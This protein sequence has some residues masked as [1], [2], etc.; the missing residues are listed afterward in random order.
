[1]SPQ[2]ARA[3]YVQSLAAYLGERYGIEPAAILDRESRKYSF[4]L[5]RHLIAYRL[6]K[7]HWTNKEI[8]ELL[9]L[10]HSTISGAIARIT[11]QIVNDPELASDYAGMPA[12]GVTSFTEHDL[13][14]LYERL[15]R[16]LAEAQFYGDRIREHLASESVPRRVT[17]LV[18]A[19]TFERRLRAWEV[20]Q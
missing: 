10:D 20:A 16:A 8:G 5:S 19:D 9:R 14:Q 2:E 3:A 12:F 7:Q 15:T 11:R 13:V 6:Y 1:M 4:A 17:N 18:T